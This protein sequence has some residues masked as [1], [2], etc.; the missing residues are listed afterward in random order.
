MGGIRKVPLSLV[1]KLVQAKINAFTTAALGNKRNKDINASLVLNSGEQCR[2]LSLFDEL[3]LLLMT[4][5]AKA[6][7]MQHFFLLGFYFHP[8]RLNK[9]SAAGKYNA[10]NKQAIG[11]LPNEFS[12]R[13][14]NT[15]FLHQQRCTVCYCHIAIDHLWYVLR[16][17]SF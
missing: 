2:Y 1:G 5:T 7:N 6:S 11:V 9:R 12:R 14:C 3:I 17:F 16:Q 13:F 15:V 10:G 8:F 4:Q